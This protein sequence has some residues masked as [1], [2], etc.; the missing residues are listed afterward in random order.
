MKIQ[1]ISIAG[2]GR[3]YN[4]AHEFSPGLN[5]VFGPNESGKSTL[6]MAI[7]TAL[8]G[9]H[10]A[11]RA[12]A[13]ENGLLRQYRPWSDSHPYGLLLEYSLD[14][15][16]EYRV[17]RTFA[18]ELRS[19]LWDLGLAR[20]VSWQYPSGRHGRLAFPKEQWGLDKELFICTACIQQGALRDVD[21]GN[22]ASSVA[23]L[24]DTGTDDATVAEACARLDAIIANDVGQTDRALQKPLPGARKQLSEAKLEKSAIETA[25]VSVTDWERQREDAGRHIEEIRRLLG[26]LELRELREQRRRTTQR[27]DR[28]ND[29]SD[30]LQ[31]ARGESEPLQAYSTFDADGREELA[32]LW[33]RRGSLLDV[34]ARLNAQIDEQAVERQGGIDHL[35]S[36]ESER[37]TLRPALGID[38]QAKREV[39]RLE[40][41][42][43]VVT[44][45]IREKESQIEQQ[46]NEMRSISAALRGQT[47]ALRLARAIGSGA[48]GELRSQWVHA[49]DQMTVA[50]AAVQHAQEAL[51]CAG[52]S[53]CDAAELHAL[54]Q[55]V[56]AAAEKTLRDLGHE[57]AIRTATE[58]AGGPAQAAA[59]TPRPHL[60]SLLALTGLILALMIFATGTVRGHTA[61]GLALGI[62]VGVLLGMA[63]LVIST[64]ARSRTGTESAIAA[65][66]GSV[67][68]GL[69][70]VSL[71]EL[72]SAQESRLQSI[73][74]TSW[75]ELEKDLHLYASINDLYAVYRH[76]DA[77]L[78][79]TKEAFSRVTERLAGIL[80]QIGVQTWDDSDLSRLGEQVHTAELARARASSLRADV[81]RVRGETDQLRALEAGQH[82]ALANLLARAGVSAKPLAEGIE[83]LK[84][85]C[86][87][88]DQLDDC[89]AMVQA[90]QGA[91]LR[92]AAAHGRDE[93]TL[94]LYGVE[95]QI[96]TII[97]KSGVVL[98]DETTC[99]E[100]YAEY[101]RCAE[102]KDARDR[103][104]A[105]QSA[106]QASID[107][108]VAGTTA[109]ALRSDL[110]MQDNQIAMLEA[111][112][113]TA[114]ST[115][116]DSCSDRE[117]LTTELAELLQLRSRLGERIQASMESHRPLSEVEEEI[118]FLEFRVAE[119]ESLRRSLTTAKE[120]LREAAE[121]Y[122]RE[123]SPRLA[124]IVRDN[125]SYVTKG[126]YSEVLVGANDLNMALMIPETGSL[127][128]LDR[129]SLGTQDELYV[130]LRLSIAQLVTDG[131]ETVPLLLDDPFVN[132]D[133]DRLDRVLELLLQMSERYQV[134][135]FTK[136]L[137]IRQWFEARTFT[138]AILTMA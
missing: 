89:L 36:L 13:S 106:L 25:L 23:A 16:K 124:R 67:T 97:G 136:D 95:S 17:Q 6:Q 14:G 69:A 52:V 132:F 44:V 130:V 2:F 81:S 138:G 77:S 88:R 35:A 47:G 78:V 75:T 135:L 91:H 37:E 100:A 26:L 3:L 131:R 104:V 56:P 64:R 137:A 73:G 22:T 38:P 114:E 68:P 87:Q 102:G 74:Y 92:R 119:L 76:A 123:F 125:L 49:R 5:L 42:L 15:G 21:G 116:F 54:R 105:H 30:Q 99:S 10:Q 70:G 113:G 39:E 90:A 82:T 98:G 29:L 62:S 66:Q 7:L 93:T 110:V 11:N 20:D 94:R 46:R 120:M 72:V 65:T 18:Q 80:Q 40:D 134:L 117:E 50:R 115:P 4:W 48:F 1:R 34:V 121:E 107:S 41:D 60:A 111:R 133:Q 103:A 79:T 126:R 32:R 59:R 83:L 112:L 24:L 101:L 12:K 127:G 128:T 71:G 51:A 28:Y 122:H 8:Y 33:E 61:L 118:C 86:A 85:L 9:F 45:Q 108:A 43:R 63:A 27:L 57:I 96:R 55:R 31:E 84:S 19:E 129:L 53:L 58:A 109:E